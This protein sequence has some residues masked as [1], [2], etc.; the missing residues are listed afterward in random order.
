MGQF[1]EFKHPNNNA[2]IILLTSK[3]AGAMVMPANGS[4]VVLGDGGTVVPVQGTLEEVKSR[5]LNALVS[6]E[7]KEEKENNSNE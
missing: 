5:I 2:D 1:I 3:I 7:N 6:I 4:V